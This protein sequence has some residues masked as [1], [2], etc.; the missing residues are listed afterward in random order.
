MANFLT[1]VAPTVNVSEITT[2]ISGMLGDFSVSNLLIF[3]G[4]GIALAAGLV[5]TWFGVRYLVRKLMGAIR[6]GSM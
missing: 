2:S 4:A 3:I 1:S 5:L 6:K